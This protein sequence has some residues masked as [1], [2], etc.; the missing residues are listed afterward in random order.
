MVVE[1]VKVVEREGLVGI[2]RMGHHS[3]ATSS[4]HVSL[5]VWYLR[6]E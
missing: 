2:R 3:Q 6:I 4:A 5:S 1:G